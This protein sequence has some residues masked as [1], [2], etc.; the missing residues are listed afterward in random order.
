MRTGVAGPPHKVRR[1]GIDIISK[2]AAFK[3]GW[4]NKANPRSSD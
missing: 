3:E 2:V 1:A 4:R